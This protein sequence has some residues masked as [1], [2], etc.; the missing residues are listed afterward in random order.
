M[1]M[2]DLDPAKDPNDHEQSDVGADELTT[3]K[4]EEPIY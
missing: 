1:Y 2:I 3:Y 4:L